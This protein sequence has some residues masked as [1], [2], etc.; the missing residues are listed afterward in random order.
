MI[1]SNMS[2]KAT[3]ANRKQILD[4]SGAEETELFSDGPG[5]IT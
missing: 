1:F 4:P 2:S 5:H 3:F